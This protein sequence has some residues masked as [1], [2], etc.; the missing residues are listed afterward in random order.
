QI[1]KHHARQLF[2]GVNKNL[3]LGQR[4]HFIAGWLPWIAD[5]VNLLFNFAALGWSIA[6][7]AAPLVFDPPLIIFSLL[8]LALFCF[9]MAKVVFLYRSARI[10]GTAPQTIAAVIAGLA[11]SHTVALAMVQGLLTKGK[12]F[13]RTP[14]MAQTAALLRALDASREES[15]FAVALWT[16]A[17]GIAYTIGTDTLDLLLWVIVLSVQSL[18]YMAALLMSI[19]SAYPKISAK[20]VCGGYCS[21]DKNSRQAI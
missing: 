16:A 9:K 7:I 3:T 1:M 18:P 13:S 2:T 11:L 5:G 4:Y 20:L 12:P 21:N 17:A 14:K 15:L 10:V 6:M 19:I 8:P